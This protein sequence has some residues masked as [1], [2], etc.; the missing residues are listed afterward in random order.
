MTTPHPT[1][2]ELE[3]AWLRFGDRLRA[4]LE[5]RLPQAADAEDVLQQVFLK[6]AASPPKDVPEDRLGAW[7]FRVARNALVDARRRA[8]VRS[9]ESLS[10]DP[11]D[12]DEPAARKS[13]TRCLEPML[14]TWEAM[15]RSC[16]ESWD[17]LIRQGILAST[18]LD[19]YNNPY[20]IDP[21]S[22]TVQP[23]KRIRQQ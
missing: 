14:K 20:A 17:P 12:T 1:V 6:M 8:T 2:P 18:P 13:L 16:P 9:A 22:C 5:R 7:L 21:V 4:W 11:V 19:N 15:H 10:T 23:M 3:A